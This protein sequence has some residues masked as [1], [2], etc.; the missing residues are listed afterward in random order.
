MLKST[1]L[2]SDRLEFKPQLHS[3]CVTMNKLLIALD[4]AVEAQKMFFFS[5]LGCWSSPSQRRYSETLR[6][7]SSE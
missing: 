7:N 2:K 3:G 4:T 6:M 5:L 1:A